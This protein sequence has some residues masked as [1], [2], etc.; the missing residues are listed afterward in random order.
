MTVIGTDGGLMPEPQDVQA[1]R[2]SMGERYEVVIDFAKY[3]IGQRVLLNNVSPP[4]NID[5]VNTHRVMAF[6]VASEATS[7]DG[8][9]VPAVLND[10]QAVMG[11]TRADAVRSEER[12]VGKE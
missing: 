4:N 10:N 2:I 8:N 5:D 11:L 1:F 9:T 7:L 3:P 12:R 6:D